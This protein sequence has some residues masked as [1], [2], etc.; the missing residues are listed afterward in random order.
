MA[1]GRVQGRVRVRGVAPAGPRSPHR[2]QEEEGPRGGSIGLRGVRFS[3]S[4]QSFLTRNHKGPRYKPRE[5]LSDAAF[6]CLLLVVSRSKG[7]RSLAPSN[8]PAE[9]LDPSTTPLFV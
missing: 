9:G 6:G 3:A 1:K 5:P 7:T 4:S 8:P 2:A